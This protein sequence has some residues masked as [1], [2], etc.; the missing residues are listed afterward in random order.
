MAG[1]REQAAGAAAGPG[2]HAV[3]DDERGSGR[4]PR[5]VQSGEG[6]AGMNCIKIGLPGKLI[7]GKR[8]AGSPILLKIVSENRF[9]GKTYFYTT[10][11]RG[12]RPTRW[13]TRPSSF[14]SSRAPSP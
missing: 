7:L 11:S 13:P 1:E 6:A 4:S 8:K 10:A 14:S 2:V 12:P 5:R 3:P 9:S